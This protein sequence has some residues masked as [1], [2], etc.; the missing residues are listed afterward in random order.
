MTADAK[1]EEITSKAFNAFAAQAR[2]VPAAHL[3]LLSA[4]DFALGPA[5]EVVIA[6]PIES[7]ET[8]E[9][10]RALR[11][12]FLP[13]SV[14]LLRS[15]GEEAEIIGIAEFTKEMKMVDGKATAYVCS[16]RVCQ[17]PTTDPDEM[18]EKLDYEKLING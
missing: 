18:L 2:G 13:R 12:R 11:S 15:E 9:M 8:E 5:S 14:V 16:G 10:L 3:H 6:G 7:P 1:L 17:R 4:L